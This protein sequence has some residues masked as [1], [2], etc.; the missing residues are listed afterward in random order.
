MITDRIGLHSVLLP[1][2]IELLSQYSIEK[3]VCTIFPL[4]FFCFN[5]LV[6]YLFYSYHF[7]CL[8]RLSVKKLFLLTAERG[9]KPEV[10]RHRAAKHNN[11][12]DGVQQVE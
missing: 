3:S 6:V 10:M 2:L 4:N 8:C 7:L 9:L 5:Y 12:Q 1:L 11:Q